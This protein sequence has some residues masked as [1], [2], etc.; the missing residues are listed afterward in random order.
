MKKFITIML[1]LAMLTSAV[2][3]GDNEKSSNSGE[4]LN[5]G[6][7]IMEDGLISGNTILKFDTLEEVT[8]CNIPN[9]GHYTSQCLAVSIQDTT[10]IIYNNCAYYFINNEKRVEADGKIDYEFKTTAMKYD[11]SEMQISNFAEYMGGKA[12]NSGYLIGSEYYFTVNNGE[13]EYDEAGNISSIGNGG[14]ATM[15]S[16]NLDTAEITEY[17]EVFDWEK[18]K[19]RYPNIQ[20]EIIGKYKDEIYLAVY[21]NNN[22]ILSGRVIAFNVKTNDFREISDNL[23][24]DMEGKYIVYMSTNGNLKEEDWSISVE[25]SDYDYHLYNLETG[26]T[27]IIEDVTY[28]GVEIC[29]G[30]MWYDNKCFDIETERIAV[31]SEYMLSLAEFKYKDSYY[32]IEDDVNKN[33]SGTRYLSEDELEKLF[34][35]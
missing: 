1:S 17:G 21:M 35:E 32:I 15:L 25:D 19:N 28:S 27:T 2:S 26:D 3:C 10:P 9:C 4:L 30:K 31:I 22:V 18:Y 16:I 29:G 13:P 6:K 8:L 23:V 20:T 11:F 7:V 5:N 14:A 34:E 12:N 33:Y 24:K